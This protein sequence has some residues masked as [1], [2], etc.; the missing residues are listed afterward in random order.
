VVNI[1]INFSKIGCEGWRWVVLAQ[2][3]V[4]LTEEL[5]LRV[6][7]RVLVHHCFCTPLSVAG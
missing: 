1:N 6:L 4:Q 3:C 5:N 2:N 7:V